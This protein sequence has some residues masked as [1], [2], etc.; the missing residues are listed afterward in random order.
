MCMFVYA[1]MI[2]LGLIGN[3]ISFFVL[4]KLTHQSSV[5]FMLRTLAIDDFVLLLCL[6]F[7]VFA[8]DT[9]TTFQVE[10][11]LYT[12]ADILWPYTRAY[13]YPLKYMALMANVL[14][15]VSIF[16]NR[17]IV[18]CQPLEAAR[19]CTTSHAKKQ[20]TFVILVSISLLLPNFWLQS[21]REKRWFSVSYGYTAR[22]QMV[23]WY[24]LHWILLDSGF[25]DS[26]QQSG[27]SPNIIA[28]FLLLTLVGI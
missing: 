21:Q 13:I 10:G 23:L 5:T 26:L 4:G 2:L 25:P 14:T 11:W 6:V 27:W 3:F 20:M 16:L 17:Y 19:L 18:V 1:P 9:A 12:A 24:L 15:S 7:R 28:L 8:D 22:K